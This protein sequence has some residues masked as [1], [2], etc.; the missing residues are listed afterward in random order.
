[1]H[2][3]ERSEKERIFQTANEIAK[4]LGIPHMKGHTRQITGKKESKL[5][6]L[7]KERN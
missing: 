2:K 7:N 4:A 5:Y 1:M 3:K 6:K